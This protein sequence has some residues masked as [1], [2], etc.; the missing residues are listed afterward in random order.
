M[1]IVSILCYVLR[2][3]A[4]NKPEMLPYSLQL[5]VTY[6]DSLVLIAILH[7]SLHWL[8]KTNHNEATN[9]CYSISSK[10]KYLKIKFCTQAENLF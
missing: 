8:R 4:S 7:F 1:L 2:N 9:I 3:E 5:S 10:I 6:H